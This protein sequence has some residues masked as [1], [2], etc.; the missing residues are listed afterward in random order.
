MPASFDRLPL[1]LIES[2][3]WVCWKFEPGQDGKI[4]KVL[5]VPVVN[6]RARHAKSSDPSTWGSF[7]DALSAF[8]SNGFD[9]I[10][11]VPSDLNEFTAI[12]VWIVAAI[13]SRSFLDCNSSRSQE[14]AARMLQ[15]LLS[16]TKLSW[17]T[18]HVRFFPPQSNK[19]GSCSP[20]RP[21]ASVEQRHAPFHHASFS[22][23]AFNLNPAVH[24]AVAFIP[25]LLP[26]CYRRAIVRQ[27]ARV[28]FLQ[29]AF[30]RKYLPGH[31]R[32]P[33]LTSPV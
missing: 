5:Y 17:K 29:G 16:L 21:A 18:F 2:P 32:A 6:G 23:G 31:S 11:F 28:C 15:Q 24:F 8:L 10:G 22:Q 1:E 26:S 25:L 20:G 9:G 19:N 12:D 4:T 33:A 7:K 13:K 14:I 30:N 27:V 3:Q